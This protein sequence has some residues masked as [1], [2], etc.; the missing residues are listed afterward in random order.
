M[1]NAVVGAL[2]LSALWMPATAAAQYDRGLILSSPE[3]AASAPLEAYEHLTITVDLSERMMYVRNGDDLVRQY[4]VA[5]GASEYPT[6]PGTYRVRRMIWNPSWTPPPSGWAKDDVYQAPGAPGNPMGRVKIFFQE[7]DYYIHGTG[8][9]GSLG[10][11][12]S[13]GCIRMR[14]TD[15]VELARLIMLRADPDKPS[16]WFRETVADPTTSREVALT[17][18]TQLRVVP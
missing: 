12:R 16:A 8:L 13:H 9:T 1:R 7:P 2:V 5:V 18:T 3:A 6:P 17:T 4:P 14:N 15:A 10:N 11:A